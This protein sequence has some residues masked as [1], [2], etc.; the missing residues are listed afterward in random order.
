[1]IG[2]L[3]AYGKNAL[4]DGTA[5]PATLY[6]QHHTGNPGTG[7]D[8]VSANGGRLAHTRTAAVNGIA[9][10]VEQM[11]TD[12]TTPETISHFSVWDALTGGNCWWTGEYAAARQYLIG[13]VARIRSGK[14]TYQV[15]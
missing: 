7:S 12:I 10:N 9:T 1:M 3:T 2:V 8:N 4:V 11:E 14:C 6:L 13:D 15:T 5:M